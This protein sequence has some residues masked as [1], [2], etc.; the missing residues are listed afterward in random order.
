VEQSLSPT[1]VLA[2]TQR[3]A[4][5]VKPKYVDRHA[6]PP[7]ATAGSVEDDHLDMSPGI[8]LGSSSFFD[9]IDPSA[10]DGGGAQAVAP[11][12]AALSAVMMIDGDT[13]IPDERLPLALR[14]QR[15]LA[16][17]AAS[18]ARPGRADSH[19]PAF[20]YALL[21]KVFF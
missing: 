8:D 21:K 18:A 9:D 11:P 19:S 14:L 12:P 6:R 20:R 15:Q 3:S 5:T 17:E 7:P 10:L 2:T 13:D 1:T 16:R 4:P